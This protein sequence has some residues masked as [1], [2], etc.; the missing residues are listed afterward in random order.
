MNPIAIVLALVALG[1][2]TSL[3]GCSQSNTPDQ[4]EVVDMVKVKADMRAV[5]NARI[6]LGHKSVGRD[7]IM[8]LESLAHET[9]VPLRVEAIDGVPSDSAPGLFHSEIGNN[10]DPDGKCEIFD[11]LLNRPEKPVYDLAMMK[12]CYSDLRENTPLAVPDML[13]RYS[14]LI[15]DLSIQRPD[16]RMVHVTLPLKADPPGR[17]TMVKRFLGRSTEED[18]DNVLRNEYNGRLRER[19][20][21]EPIFDLASVESTH[22]DGSRSEFSH[23]GSPV[24]T[25]AAEYTDDGGHLNAA[26]RRRAAIEFV[27][28]VASALP[29]GG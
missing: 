22:M 8:G 19:F 11:L 24:Y 29:T 4:I 16:V 18:A 9:G 21:N 15:Q 23:D 17:K 26:G 20:S 28:V 3:S 1:A 6:L 7:I 25:L 13:D 27:R 12:F 2:V 10:G 5:A 14:R